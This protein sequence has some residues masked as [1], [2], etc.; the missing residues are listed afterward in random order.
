MRHETRVWFIPAVVVGL[1]ALVWSL[2][3]APKEA[4][5]RPERGKQVLRVA[6]AARP[7]PI[8]SGKLAILGIALPGPMGTMLLR[9]AL[10]PVQWV[11]RGRARREMV[12]LR[13]SS[14][15]TSR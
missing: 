6:P 13:T 2:T 5:Q 14:P 12:R 15:P 10:D 7:E 9:S 8:Q 1:V 4:R 11:P 3:A